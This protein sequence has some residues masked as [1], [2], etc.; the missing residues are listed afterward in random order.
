M[1][2]TDSDK[3]N[4]RVLYFK[5]DGFKS[6]FD[7]RKSV[8]KTEVAIRKA[9]LNKFIKASCEAQEPGFIDESFLLK[10]FDVSLKIC[11]N[12]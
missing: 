4:G 3:A 2:I 8:S 9:E 5:D 6:Y 7:T 1:T 10:T 12:I 11:C